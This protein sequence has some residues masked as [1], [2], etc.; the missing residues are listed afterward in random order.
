MQDEIRNPYLLEFLDLKDEYDESDL[1]EALVCHLEWF[2]LE[3]GAGFTFVARQKR[4]RIGDEWYRIDL[5]LFHRRLRCLVVVDLKIG[6]FTHADAGQMNL[7]LNY[8]RENMIKTG[9][10]DP[11]GLIFCSA[12]NEAVVHYAMGGIK[13]NVFASH[14]LTDLPDPETLRQEILTT[15]HALETRAAMKGS[16]RG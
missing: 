9:E 11:V 3:L 13:A 14:Y 5:L 7:Y 16:D 8:V 10:N 4:I 2:L 12:T 6:K 1:E 15:Q